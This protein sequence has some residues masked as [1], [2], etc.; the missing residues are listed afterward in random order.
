[1]RE[2]TRV[3][4]KLDDWPQLDRYR[5]A[6]SDVKPPAPDE[7]RVVFLGDSITDAWDDPKYG[8]FFP[9]KPYIDRGISGQTTP[10]MVLRMQADVIALKPKVMVLLAGTNDLASNTGTITVEETQSNITTM[11][12]LAVAHGIKVV[13]SSILPVSAYHVIAADPRGPQTTRRPPDKIKVLNAWMQA[14]AKEHGHV[15]LDYYTAM[16][17]AQG[18]FRTELSGD[19]LHPNAAGYAIMAPLAE[20]AIKEALAK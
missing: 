2:L 18:M 4:T 1:V 16:L 13:L 20:A 14:Y 15:Y 17:D 19:D 6:N 12:E 7:A 8:G 3:K 9:G 5:T 10:Q 11:A